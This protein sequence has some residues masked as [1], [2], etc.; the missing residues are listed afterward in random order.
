MR[1][2]GNAKHLIQFE[3]IRF[4]QCWSNIPRSLIENL[5]LFEKFL[6]FRRGF[7]QLIA[8]SVRFYQHLI[9]WWEVR[10]DCVLAVSGCNF[11]Y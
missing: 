10:D 11:T 4:S 1:K 2:S 7:K 3:K 8:M 6:R 9:E 5:Q